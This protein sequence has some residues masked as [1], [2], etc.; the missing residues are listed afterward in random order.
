MSD[1]YLFNLKVRKI[2]VQQTSPWIRSMKIATQKGDID[3]NTVIFFFLCT[4]ANFRLHNSAKFCN[5]VRKQCYFVAWG[6]LRK[7]LWPSQKSWTLGVFPRTAQEVSS[8][9]HKYLRALCNC[10]VQATAYTMSK[11]PGSLHI[12]VGPFFVKT[13]KIRLWDFHFHVFCCC[14]S[15]LLSKKVNKLLHNILVTSLPKRNQKPMYQN[16]MKSSVM[17]L[18]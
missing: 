15:S 5:T 10:Y 1:I 18:T 14:R 3:N 7:F 11:L 12:F 4:L 16:G 9:S 2:H 13:T 6:R 8:L 17:R